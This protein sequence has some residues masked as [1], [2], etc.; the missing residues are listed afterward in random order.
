MTLNKHTD[1]DVIYASKTN[2][3]NNECLNI[4]GL[5]LIRELL[6]RDIDFSAGLFDWW[7]D[8]Y[9]D[10]T[11]RENSVDTGNT[12]SVFNSTDTTYET[13]TD[14]DTLIYMDIPSGT[15]NTTITEAIGVP[16]IHNWGTGSIITY[17]LTNVGTDDSGYLDCGITPE[18]S[19]FTVFS[20]GEPDTIIVK[21]TDMD[22]ISNPIGEPSFET[23]VGWSATEVDVSGTLSQSQS[24][25]QH[26]DGSNSWKFTKAGDTNADDYLQIS[27]TVDFSHMEEFSLY[28][29]KDAADADLRNMYLQVLIN[30]VSIINQHMYAGLP[31]TTWTKLSGDITKSE[32]GSYTLKIRLYTTSLSVDNYDGSVYI[33]TCNIVQEKTSIKGFVVKA[34]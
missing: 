14:A 27:R 30:D 28:Y 7:G 18:I 15:F 31:L 12:T 23:V 13:T 4:S 9:I 5:N 17:K 20:N 11:G 32:R 8:A 1:G 19:S 16:F 26:Q 2:Q 21:L 33:D 34:T 24:A 25:T 3:D 6:D 29:Y 22:A 10:A